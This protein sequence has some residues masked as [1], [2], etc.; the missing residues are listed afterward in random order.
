MHASQGGHRPCSPE[1]R[2]APLLYWNHTWGRWEP[3]G[4]GCARRKR[5]SLGVEVDW[6][7][8]RKSVLG[9]RNPWAFQALVM[10][11]GNRKGRGDRDRE[12]GSRE[13][14]CTA[15]SW[16]LGTGPPTRLLSLVPA[17]ESGVENFP[18][19]AG[20]LVSPCSEL[21]TCDKCAC[22]PP[23][24]SPPP[25]PWLINMQLAGPGKGGAWN[26][27]DRGQV[28]LLTLLKGSFEEQPLLSREV[29]GSKEAG[30]SEGRAVGPS[31]HPSAPPTPPPAPAPPLLTSKTATLHVSARDQLSL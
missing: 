24:R 8:P 26:A 22:C 14:E 10:L 17:L 23:L 13:G 7:H 9:V 27:V 1:G 20:P 3:V 11:T 25:P 15:R 6:G 31:P 19:P 21:V 2:E 30:M 29:Q 12:G 5:V 4:L 16:K 28:L 18:P